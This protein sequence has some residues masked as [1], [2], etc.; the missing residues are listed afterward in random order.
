MSGLK[1][2]KIKESILIKTL[3]VLAL[4]VCFA[5]PVSAARDFK[6]QSTAGTPFFFIEGDNGNVGI[7]TIN[8]GYRL[9]IL[10]PDAID[11]FMRVQ[12]YDGDIQ[13]GIMLSTGASTPLWTM[14]VDGSSSNLLFE[15]NAVVSATIT[16]DGYFGIGPDYLTPTGLLDVNN[17]F[18]VTDQ[19]VTMN[20]P[21][22]LAAAGDISIASDLQFTSPTASYIKSYA[23]L[24]IEAGDP[25]QNVDL[26]LRGSNLGKVIVDDNLKVTGQIDLSN[27]RIV[28]LGTPTDDTDAATKDY[29]DSSLISGDSDWAGVGG[30]PTLAGEIYHTGN[31]GIGTTDPEA[32]LQVAGGNIILD[33]NQ[34][35]RWKNQAGI[36]TNGIFVSTNNDMVY[37]ATLGK[38]HIFQD[39]AANEIMRITDEGSTGNVGIGSISPA[40]KLDVNGNIQAA[41]YY[42]RD[43][44][45]YYINPAAGGTGL[46]LRSSGSIYASG[47]DDNYFAGDVG[48]GTTVPRQKLDVIG[49]LIVAN[50]A[51]IPA[52]YYGS[53]DF[54]LFGSHSSTGTLFEIFN[55]ADT[56]IV[57]IL[58]GG[59]VGI[60]TTVPQYK[61]DVRG[62]V[63]VGTAGATNQIH[64]VA[65]PTANT[66]AATKGYVDDASVDH[67]STADYATTAGSADHATYANSSLRSLYLGD[68][69]NV[70]ADS[71]GNLQVNGTGNSYL[72]GKVGIGTTVPQY[73]LDVR[74]AV[75]VGTA[76][77]TNQIHFV[78]TPTTTTDAA[79]KGYVDDAS[80]DHAAT[81]DYATTAGSAYH[82]TYANSSLRS[83]YLG[84]SFNVTADSLG[85]LQVNGTGN[86]YLMGKVGIGTTSAGYKLDVLSPDDALESHIQVQRFDGDVPVGFILS[87]GASSPVWTM[88]ADGGSSDLLFEEDG[89]VAATITT[90]GYFGIGPDYL[91][92]QGLLDVNNKFIVTD[93]QVTMNVP[94]N[95]AAAGDISIASDLQFTSP[96]ASYI[97]SYAPLYLQAGDSNH[98]Y[99]LTLRAFNSGEVVSDAQMNLANNKIVSLGTPTDNTDAAT[100]GYVDSAAGGGVSSGTDG[101]TIRNSSGDWIAN[102]FLYNTGSRIGIG[103]TIPSDTLTLNSGNIR[104]KS[105]GAL[106]LDNTNNNNPWYIGNQ[107]GGLATLAFMKGGQGNEYIKMTVD[108]SSNVGIG[109]TAPVSK[110]H[111]DDGLVSVLK[112]S[113]GTYQTPTV[114]SHL[115]PK[116]YVDDLFEGDPGVAGAYW[117]KSATG[118]HIYN[119]NTGNVGIGNL[120]PVSPGLT[121]RTDDI[122]AVDSA[123]A[124][125]YSLILHGGQGVS[126][127]EEIGLAF[128]AW[129]SGGDMTNSYTPGA[130]ITHE[131]S[132]GNSK[133]HLLFKTK[134]STV[135][136]GPLTTKMIIR[137]DGNVGIGVTGPGSK[138][139]INTALTIAPASTPPATAPF[140]IS[141]SADKNTILNMGIDPSGSTSAWMQVQHVT[142]A[143]S[144]Y[145]LN[146]NPMGGNV[147][148]GVT[149]PGDTLEVRTTASNGLRLSVPSSYLKDVGPRMEFWNSS[150]NELASIQGS[151]KNNSDG[152]YG[153]LDFGVRTSD[154][155][156]VQTKVS[157]L[158]DGNVGIGTADPQQE[159]HV[160]GDV[161]GS[162]YYDLVDSNY[163]LD[164]GANIYS[165]G[166]YSKGSVYSE[167]SAD[168]YF[169]GNV[170]IGTTV[171]DTILTIANDEWISA[172]DSAGTGHVNMFKVNTSNEIEVGGTLNIGTIGLAEDSGVVTLVNMPVSSTPSVGTEESYSFAIDSESILKVYSEA[173]GTGGIQ[174][175]RVGI[176]TTSPS[177]TLDVW[178]DLYA[179]Q[180]NITTDNLG[181]ITAKSFY[182]KD[183]VLYYL[184]PS[185]TGTSL[186]LAGVIQ[187]NGSGDN[188]FAGN[189]GIGV[190][191]PVTRTEI[192]N[193]GGGIQRTLAL[194]NE[195]NNSDVGSTLEFRNSIFNGVTWLG[196]SIQGVR[197]GSSAG[198]SIV[199]NTK[200]SGQ[201]GEI[202]SEAMR[203]SSGNVGIGTTSPSYTL[204]VAG[205]IGIDEYIYHNDDTDTYQ[206][207]LNDRWIM[208]AGGENMIDAT[209]NATQ[210]YFYIGDGGD[211]DTWIKS[212]NT[213]LFVEGNSGNVGIGT[214]VP[215][216]KLDVRGAVAVGAAGA[217]N[218]IHYVATPTT[219][220]DAAT[221][222]YVDDASVDHAS[223]ADYATTAG[224]ADHAT[225]AN[226]ALR[227]LYLGD[228]F[229][230]T[231]DSQGNLQVDGT[232]DSYLMGN[233]GIG[234]TVPQH[235]LDVRGA[236]AVGTAG[237]T[238]QIHFLATPILGTDAANRAYIDDNF[239]PLAGGEPGGTGDA[240]IQ[241][242]NSF[243]A[244]ATLGTND[245]YDLTFETN[246]SRKMTILTGGNVGIG[247]TVPVGLLHLKKSGSVWLYI[248]SE[249]STGQSG[250]VMNTHGQS[251]LSNLGITFSGSSFGQ[252]LAGKTTLTAS[253]TTGLIIGTKG[254]AVP[255]NLGTNGISRIFIEGAGY[256]GIGTTVPQSALDVDGLIK[257][258]DSTITQDEDVINLGYL[259]AA[260]DAAILSGD[261]DWSYDADPATKVYNLTADIGI[262]TNVPGAKLDV[263]ENTA[264]PIDNLRVS[265]DINY[266]SLGARE[267][268]AF[269]TKSSGVG[270]E[271]GVDSVTGDGWTGSGGGVSF[272]TN[273]AGLLTTKM[274]IQNNG[275]VA[276]GTTSAGYKLDILAPDA[277]DSYMRVQRYDAEVQAGIMLA[278]GASTPLWTMYVDS[279]PRED[280]FFEYDGEVPFTISE[281]GRVG[282]GTTVPDTILTIAN[283]SWIS[284]KDSAGTGHVNMFKVNTSNEIEVGGTLNIGTIG[285]AED[286]GVVTLVNMP[287]SSTPTAGTEESYSFAIDSEAILKVYSE[288]DGTGG[289][290]NKRVG[291]GTTSPS[292]TLDV[293]GDL[294]ADQGNI[295]TD[296]LGNITAKS[297]Y[298]KDSVLYYLDPATTGTSLNLAGI[299]Q[300]NGSGDNYFAGDVGIKTTTPDYAL[301]VSGDVRLESTNRLRFSG[302]GSGDWGSSLRHESGL[303]T[304]NTAGL[305]IND[306]GYTGTK[307]F[308]TILN[309]GNVGI[310]TT[311][312]DTLLHLSKADGTSIIRLERDDWNIVTDEI[313][314][315]LQFE[316]QDSSAAS[317]A[318]VRGG[319]KG[320][321][322]GTTGQ[323]ALTFETSGSYDA[324]P[325]ERI[326]IA[327][328]GNVGIGT[329]VPQYKLD[330]RG[331]VAVG[332]AG[333]TNQIHYVAVPTASTDAATMGYVDDQVGGAGGVGTGIANQTLRHDGDGWVASSTI[334]NNG[335]NVGIG[336]ANPYT[337]LHIYESGAEATH[338]GT[339]EGVMRLVSNP[340][341]GE[342]VAL[343]FT[344]Y[345][346][347]DRDLARISMKFGPGLSSELHFGTSNTYSGISNTAM[348]IDKDGNIGIGTATSQGRLHVQTAS[349]VEIFRTED[350]TGSEAM[351]IDKDGNVIIS[352]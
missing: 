219:T 249:S 21:L 194:T 238:N 183:N 14:Y 69:F 109:T 188:Y 228:S 70:T 48:I 133:G 311:V 256:V 177:A 339:G 318:G 54:A 187:A 8:P 125:Q 2:S 343:G 214:T 324:T 195:Q 272:L 260:I 36:A 286:S 215:G 315:A 120:I 323:M 15:E 155:L 292:A 151:F 285:L 181:N 5:L 22:N 303:L 202:V 95:L 1:N 189:V 328:E 212:A 308:F 111:I 158:N 192:T 342:F 333:A 221:K 242:G 64:F 115:T 150:T 4:V 313:Y 170:G 294:Y 34:F 131:R 245:N 232:G 43:N 26:T 348:V 279:G 45:D 172:K 335:T 138:L 116:G 117:T 207:S 178:G 59:N 327:G 100:K 71:L 243:G 79:T 82:A 351:V 124:N 19:Q 90:D 134:N 350:E 77:A 83:L 106:E 156:G 114:D 145:P 101:Q 247:T 290:Q 84:D 203:I 299:I 263:H 340:N 264:N 73:K 223:T 297:F 248:D 122:D 173:D 336:T 326:R 157:I 261:P 301:D 153:R 338:T 60:G 174:N 113:D 132:G 246:G 38:D 227:A 119:N 44:S 317:A 251:I 139:H 16:T 13:A 345:H 52:G 18:I 184:D 146:L 293:W 93:T 166:L 287:V 252:T 322:E 250:I 63:A 56:S 103:T 193:T 226:S 140:R 216:H 197:N 55:A 208:V 179:D 346:Y 325:I 204:D 295:T 163:Y 320:I 35:L 201:D 87:T 229:N 61:L 40:T 37:K 28:G 253:S 42:D 129:A 121:I 58:G 271:L 67:A 255:L 314:G 75:A 108:N 176:G 180:G 319:I 236:V 130:A 102:S 49:N 20:V 266:L 74:G 169:A 240:F 31:V 262:G 80:V 230:V 321:S 11:S 159:L 206:R 47:V 302:T 205:N 200:R 288:A 154:A 32:K 196:A 78:A 309:S 149:N 233:V 281:D 12:R 89:T 6:V 284:A 306:D 168:N 283:D 25:S 267:I 310:G 165:Y 222:G 123:T 239:L 334:Y 237:A 62:A 265:G 96:T 152:N 175:K 298:D 296:N 97:K 330:V 105:N 126:D 258:R 160:Q 94:L 257:M 191:N 300:A 282:I 268:T 347:P 275:N 99:D 209:E 17:K 81:A 57:K 329:T 186:N 337:P 144:Y 312:P 278:T 273:D 161:I 86:S 235:K 24:Y 341:A 185:E 29:V 274:F 143:G 53:S 68:S 276:I 231:A 147:G 72:M 76:G 98:S 137:D 85:N 210:D 27:S 39:S 128:N 135:A 41:Y 198:H 254:N 277:T 88:Y 30:D 65:T 234:T 217:T 23:P 3:A 110:L 171:P 182:D 304:I 211:I 270:L 259:E 305:V 269:R 46:G 291:I 112:S 316:G 344:E 280:L 50:S 164:P 213:G 127:G 190:T 220:T 225:Y 349:D 91:T 162:V 167:G 9:D 289:I 331:A 307:D 224:S 10:S 51:S 136:T 218:Q 7:S 66:D 244:L 33:N 199:F 241:G 148:I 118:D 107:G 104:L 141:A 332:T 92:P 142:T 352:L